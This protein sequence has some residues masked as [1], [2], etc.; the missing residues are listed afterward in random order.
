MGFELPNVKSLENRVF[1]I[2]NEEEVVQIALEVFR[3]QYLT[4][5]VYQSFCD[6]LGRDPGSVSDLAQIPFLPIQFFKSMEVKAGA[7]KR[8]R[9]KQTRL[10]PH[11]M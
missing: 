7:C 5:N 10:Q 2:R 8:R 3:Y 6:A 11:H 1:R 9:G 4:N